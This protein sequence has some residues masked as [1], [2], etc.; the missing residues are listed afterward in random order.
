MTVRI[1]AAIE[2]G[3]ALQVGL[4]ARVREPGP[5]TQRWFLLTLKTKVLNAQRAGA[6][7]EYKDPL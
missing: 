4:P 5:S 3:R 1:I 2:R 7:T 6:P